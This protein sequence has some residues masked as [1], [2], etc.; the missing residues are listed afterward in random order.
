MG[1]GQVLVE[2]T[3]AMREA[4]AAILQMAAHSDTQKGPVLWAGAA[5]PLVELLANSAASAV[6]EQAALAVRPSGACVWVFHMTGGARALSERGRGNWWGVPLHLHG[7][8]FERV[9]L[10]P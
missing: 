7:P 5:E 9:V 2:G 3:D 8:E 10:A 1:A 4:A 6:R